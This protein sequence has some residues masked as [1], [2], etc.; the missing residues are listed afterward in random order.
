METSI[1]SREELLQRAREL[2]RKE[3][4]AFDL[5]LTNLETR[6]REQRLAKM[7]WKPR[8]TPESWDDEDASFKQLQLQGRIGELND[9]VRAIENSVAWRAIQ[10]VRR[11][12]G[13]AW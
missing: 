9:Y 10:G 6:D 12:I 4:E 8:R 3:A 1:T 11:L 13:R 7:A 2:G 5:Q